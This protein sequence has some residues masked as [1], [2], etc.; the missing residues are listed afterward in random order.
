MPT[1]ANERGKEMSE[2]QGTWGAWFGDF[3]TAAAAKR[4]LTM[5]FTGPKVPDRDDWIDSDVQQNGEGR[6]KVRLCQ[7]PYTCTL[8]EVTE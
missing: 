7:A 4:Y 2:T 5:Q 1:R 8:W 3:A 6:W